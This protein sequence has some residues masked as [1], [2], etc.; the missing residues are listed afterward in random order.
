MAPRVGDL[1]VC[2]K[3][4]G[5]RRADQARL[6]APQARGIGT[7]QARG[8][9]TPQARGIGTP[10]A[11]GIFAL[12]LALAL[13]ACDR[14][15]EV[16]PRPAFANLFGAHLEGR[17]PPPGLDQPWPNLASVPPRPEAP[18]PTAREELTGR[19]A[20]D[21]ER[22]RTPQL[23]SLAPRLPT[24]AGP[25]APPVLAAMPAIRPGP[26]QPPVPAALPAP[27]PAPAPRP[28]APATMPVPPP[29]RTPAPMPA[30]EVTPA[31]RPAEP[32]APPPPPTPD[33]FAPPPPP[34]SDLLAPRRN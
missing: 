34:S 6:V 26:P 24:T 21:R 13:P 25:P 19:L 18:S 16:D 3:A 4:R 9:G 14:L 27:Q 30:S 32:L 33:L 28:G 23:S 1:G 31:P 22:A 15:S 12:A 11:R 17:E 7:P 2:R 8:I 29:A 5:W 10:Q 20:T